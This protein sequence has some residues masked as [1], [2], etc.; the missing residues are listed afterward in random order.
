MRDYKINPSYFEGLLL[1]TEKLSKIGPKPP[2]SRYQ[3]GDDSDYAF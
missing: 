1:Y 3:T 2:F